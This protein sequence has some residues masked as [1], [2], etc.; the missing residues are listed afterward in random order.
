MLSADGLGQGM[1][2]IQIKRHRT[3]MRAKWWEQTLQKKEY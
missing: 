1:V 2:I 3:A